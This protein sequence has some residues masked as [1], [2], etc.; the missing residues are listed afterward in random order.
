MANAK[1]L[2]G[3]IDYLRGELKTVLDEAGDNFDMGKVKHIEGDSATKVD[4][5]KKTDTELNALQ[6]EH[7]KQKII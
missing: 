4:W 1:E 2:K 5:I 7:D 6:T 3:K